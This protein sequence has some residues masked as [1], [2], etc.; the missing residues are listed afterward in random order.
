MSYKI[1]LLN[2]EF[3]I[4]AA[5]TNLVLTAL[6]TLAKREQ[7]FAFVKNSVLISSNNIS[8]AFEAWRWLPEIDNQ[9][10]IVDLD[11]MGEKLGD[12]QILFDA[13]APFVEAESYIIFAGENGE[14]GKVW[15]WRFDGKLCH[16]EIGKINF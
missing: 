2:T 5:N 16:Y 13:I 15:R 11:F 14:T 6:R 9:G 4:V 7:D 3:C 8:S 10:N 1:L 12:E